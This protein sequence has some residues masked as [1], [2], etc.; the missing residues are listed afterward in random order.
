MARPRRFELLTPRFVVRGRT[1]ILA[2]FSANGAQSSPLRINTLVA[3]LQTK[4]VTRGRAI[5]MRQPKNTVRERSA[6]PA[7]HGDYQNR[8]ERPAHPSNR[9]VVQVNASWRV[10]DDPPAM[11]AAA[12][13]GQ[14]PGKGLWLA[15][16]FLLHHAG[17]TATLPSRVL[18]R[19][20]A[21]CVRQA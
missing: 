18:R 5:T 16:P 17:R 9:L 2:S 19:C 12:E 14:P 10:I 4:N 8:V 6:T 3:E 7:T 1:L 11:D 20:R 15:K 13:E 21:S